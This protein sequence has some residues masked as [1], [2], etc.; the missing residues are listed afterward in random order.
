[1]CAAARDLFA[2]AKLL[3][4]TVKRRLWATRRWKLH[5]PVFSCIHIASTKIAY[6]TRSVPL[7]GVVPANLCTIYLYMAVRT[8]GSLSAAGI[9]YLRSLSHRKEAI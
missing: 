5:A 3:F 2:I 8:W 1:V 6:F 7:Q 4:E 9:V